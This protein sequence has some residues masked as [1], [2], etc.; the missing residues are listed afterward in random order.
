MNVSMNGKIPALYVVVA[1][2]ILE[3]LKASSTHSAISSLA[4]SAIA[5]FG[6]PLASNFSFNSST[7]SL[8]CPYTDV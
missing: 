2:T 4:K 1:R 7:A 8:V 6:V 5:I 3:Y